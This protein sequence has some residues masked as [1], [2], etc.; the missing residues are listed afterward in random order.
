MGRTQQRMNHVQIQIVKQVCST[1]MSTT[2]MIFAEVKEAQKDNKRYP[3]V[4]ENPSQTGLPSCQESLH[5]VSW[6][7]IETGNADTCGSIFVHDCV[8]K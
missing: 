1:H 3:N 2:E 8:R 4:I 6:L 7:F 5:S